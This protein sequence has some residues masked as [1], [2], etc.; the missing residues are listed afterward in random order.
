[1]QSLLTDTPENLIRKYSKA[2]REAN[3]PVEALI[4][5]G[6]YAKH[7][8]TA[9]S[10]VDVCVVSSL[11]GKHPFDEMVMLAKIA[12]TIDPMIELHPYSLEDLQDEWDPLAREIRN[13]G[14]VIETYPS[15]LR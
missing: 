6:S 3:I 5:F 12:A 9:S 11:F 15:V 8:E 1:M 2:L 14:K 10:D 4:L 13:Y 7:T